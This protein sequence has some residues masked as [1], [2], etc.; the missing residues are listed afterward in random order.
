MN[1]SSFHFDSCM[2]GV[3][4]VL[5]AATCICLRFRSCLPISPFYLSGMGYFLPHPH[6]VLFPDFF[7]ETDHAYHFTR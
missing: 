5:L 6:G 3:Y 2:L 7:L 4:S 1:L